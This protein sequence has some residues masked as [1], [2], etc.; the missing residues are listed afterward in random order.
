[1]LRRDDI[2]RENVRKTLG[3][4]IATGGWLIGGYAFRSW[5]AIGKAA[6][7]WAKRDKALIKEHEAEETEAALRFQA[8]LGKEQA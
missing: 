2:V 7:A 3:P 5:V 8:Q 6:A 4:E 1:M